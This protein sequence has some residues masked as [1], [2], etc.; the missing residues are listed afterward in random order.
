MDK[1]NNESSIYPYM[2]TKYHLD[3][4][5]L[6]GKPVVLYNGKNV[7]TMKSIIF[8]PDNDSRWVIN[9]DSKNQ[10]VFDNLIKDKEDKLVHW[11]WS[12]PF[13]YLNDAAT[14]DRLEENVGL[15][16]NSVVLPSFNTSV[17]FIGF[18]SNDNFSLLSVH[19]ENSGVGRFLTISEKIILAEKLSLEIEDILYTGIFS[20]D[21]I[22]EGDSVF[23][24]PLDYSDDNRIFLICP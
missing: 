13:K 10:P 11:L 21:L 9:S 24:E 17:A 19:I 2:V 3:E 5:Y 23:I 8:R 12:D 1:I 16:F 15:P 6:D 7:D 20:K 14:L 22:D 18:G 4:N